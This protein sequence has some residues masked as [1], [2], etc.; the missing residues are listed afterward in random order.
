MSEDDERSGVDWDQRFQDENTPWERS[1]AHPAMALWSRTGHLEAGKT[2]IVP[3]CGRTDDLHQLTSLGL[4]TTGLDL[5]STAISWQRQ[6]LGTARLTANLHVGDAFK[7]QPET[8][9]DLV[10]EQTFLCA[11]P[12][13]LRETYEQTVFQWLRPGGSLLALFMQKDEPGGPPY[14]CSLDAMRILF[15]PSRWQWPDDAHWTA[16][17]H[18]SLNDKA[19]LAGHLTRI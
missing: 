5:S 15:P 7:Y 8:P 18:P 11:I 4:K 16:F 17:P 14:G 19:E 9:C 13:R 2:C 1:G 3:G 10:W 12:P 6:Q